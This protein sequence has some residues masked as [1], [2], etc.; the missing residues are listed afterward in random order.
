[1]DLVT[2]QMIVE[3][4]EDIG[5]PWPLIGNNKIRVVADLGDYLLL[6]CSDDISAFDEVMKNAIPWKGI[7]LTQTSA[8]WFKQTGLRWHNHF[9]SA[10]LNEFP[11]EILGFLGRKY[12]IF[13]ERT[14]LVLKAKSVLPYEFIARWYL[15]GSME[16]AYAATG[17]FLD[18]ILPRG[19]KKGDPLPVPFFNVSTKAGRGSHDVNLSFNAFGELV[20]IK[21][22]KMLKDL[23]LGFGND[24]RAIADYR[25]LVYKD[26]KIEI[27]LDESGQSMIID[28]VYT[29]D[30]ARVV[31]K[32]PND[33]RDLSKEPV[34]EYLK[35]IGR[36]KGTSEIL[37]DWLVKQTSESYLELYRMLTGKT[38]VPTTT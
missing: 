8:W 24:V 25:G 18:E 29:S 34:R 14:M 9:I 11:P 37:P 5:C 23:T 2:K 12:K 20:G 1:M 26:G 6:I 10:D 32:E 22:A 21:T 4:L 3:T 7:A 15:E 31:P 16:K 33:K 30:A 36:D 35:S 38:I 13:A 28:E 19:L 27:G 17:M